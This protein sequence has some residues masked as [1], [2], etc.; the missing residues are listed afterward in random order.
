MVAGTVPVPSALRRQPQV[1]SLVIRSETES[2]GRTACGACLLLF[3]QIKRTRRR[4]GQSFFPGGDLALPPGAGPK[5][6]KWAGQESNLLNHVLHRG[7][8][9]CI[10]LYCCP[11]RVSSETYLCVCHSATPPFDD[12]GTRTHKTFRSQVPDVLQ[13]AVGLFRILDRRSCGQSLT[14][15]AIELRRI[16]SQ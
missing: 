8:R 13:Q 10:V 7:S 6:F 11:T 14:C 3:L 12:G 5:R 2:F 4:I 16:T 1:D 9:M 15:S